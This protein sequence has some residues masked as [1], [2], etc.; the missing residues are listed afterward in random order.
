M[1]DKSSPQKMKK[2]PP[3]QQLQMLRA[4]G[5]RIV[6]LFDFVKAEG[7]MISLPMLLNWGFTVF[8]SLADSFYLTI[9][10]R[11]SI[12]GTK[13][14]RSLS[15]WEAQGRTRNDLGMTLMS[16]WEPSVTEG[17]TPDLEKSAAIQHF[18]VYFTHNF[19]P[20]DLKPWTSIS[21]VAVINSFTSIMSRGQDG[22]TTC[23]AVRA[24][25][26]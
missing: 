17:C 16:T 6:P 5:P 25:K 9:K 23:S 2:K 15:L 7:E 19:I 21:T 11:I 1:Q 4:E 26:C 18:N 13:V 3:P 24:G 22:Q 14:A 20:M 10:R 8:S 12:F